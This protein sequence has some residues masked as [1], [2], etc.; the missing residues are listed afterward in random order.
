MKL[1]ERDIDRLVD[2][3]VSRIAGSLPTPHSPLPNTPTPNFPT[4][5]AGDPGLFETVDAAVEAAQHAL[6]E[7]R[8]CGLETRFKMIEAMRQVTLEHNDSLSRMTVAE[9][10]LGRV[11][12]K[13]K[14]NLCAASKTP[15]PEILS[16]E[17][18]SG[19]DGL[20]IVEFAPFGVI[21]AVTPCT[22]ATETIINNA[23]SI[24]SGGN[25]VV[26]NV[27]PSAKGV[28]NFHVALLN[29]AVISAGGPPN[30]ICS[31]ITPTIQSAQQ[32]MT[33]RGI[34]L[35]VVTGG[36]AVVKAAMSSGKRAIAAG[37]GNPPVIVDETADIQRAA[38]GVIDGCSVDNNIVC[39]A[40][41]ELI[42]VADIADM[43]KREMIAYSAVEVKGRDLAK[44]EKLLI[45]E[46]NHV[47][48][49]FVGK[50][51]SLI[52]AEVGIRIG[53]DV[54]LLL[55][56]VDEQHPFVQ[57][58]MLLPVLGMIR[59]PN[60]DAAIDMA[61]RVEH[62]NRHT[63]VMYSTNIGSMHRMAVECDCSIFVKNAP[64]Y[65]GIG[66]GGEGFT[67]WT[68]A[69]PTGEGLTNARTF[70]RIRRCTLKEYFRFV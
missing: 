22:N 68:I 14:K 48:R 39:I 19:D 28:C 66:M 8:D 49:D 4:A 18:F 23:I 11:E 63:A 31:I 9:T 35:I 51:A 53:D 7:F 10:G 59:V 3:V 52:A 2:R 54:R 62:G 60:V 25:T 41:K 36:P 15:G 50:N 64:C 29:K 16:P 61:I 58:E 70:T 26:F 34:S 40:E 24:V 30:V 57:H 33:H 21:G 17:A 69:G 56:E 32:V 46:D 5:G 65:A 37:P 47:N 6:R 44:L 20:A 67:S 42:A 38:R 13:L 1:T 12:D 45:T 43:L 55:C 27:H